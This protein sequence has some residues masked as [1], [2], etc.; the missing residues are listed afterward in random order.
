MRKKNLFMINKFINFLLQRIE[1][2]SSVGAIHLGM[3]E[4]KR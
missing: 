4:L 3:V 1:E 2:V